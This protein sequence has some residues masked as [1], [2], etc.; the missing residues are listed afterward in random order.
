MNANT[1]LEVAS[2]L[3]AFF[4]FIRG[5]HCSW[6]GFRQYV[7]TPMLENL[8]RASGFQRQEQR[9][10][11]RTIVAGEDGR[12]VHDRPVAVCGERRQHAY[13]GFRYS[14]RTVHDRE[15]ALP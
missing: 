10:P 6:S 1:F 5:R 4:A 3:F 7:E 9:T 11:G 8:A 12:R 13:A 14:T 2:C 15:R